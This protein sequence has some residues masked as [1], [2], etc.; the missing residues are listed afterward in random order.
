MLTLKIMGTPLEH[1]YSG[2]IKKSGG[3]YSIQQ[4][5]KQLAAIKGN[6]DETEFLMSSNSLEN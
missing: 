4:G 2:H 1:I 5:N 6:G 3:K